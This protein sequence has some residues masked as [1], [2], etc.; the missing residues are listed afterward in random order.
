MIEVQMCATRAVPTGD[1]RDADILWAL[2]AV[3]ND[4]GEQY[5]IQKGSRTFMSCIPLT[6]GP[7]LTFFFKLKNL[8]SCVRQDAHNYAKASVPGSYQ[9]N[10]LSANNKVKQ[11]KLL[12]KDDNYLYRKID[13]YGIDDDGWVSD[14]CPIIA[15]ITNETL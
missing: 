5:D 2:K 12:F 4:M 1:K 7:F 13:E 15:C 9:L 10:T 3:K 14:N 8:Y 6:N 11:I